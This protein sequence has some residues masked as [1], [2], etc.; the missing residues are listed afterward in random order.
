MRKISEPEL[1]PEWSP[2]V[3]CNEVKKYQGKKEPKKQASIIC[4]FCSKS[5]G[6]H[7][8]LKLFILLERLKEIKTS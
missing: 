3:Q 6:S 1:I 7:L 2:R 4:N 8:A 5:L